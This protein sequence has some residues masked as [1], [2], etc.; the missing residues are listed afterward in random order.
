LTLNLHT[1][2]VLLLTHTF[3]KHGHINIIVYLDYEEVAV[4]VVDKQ[5]TVED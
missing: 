2:K 4:I 5:V 3:V 1:V